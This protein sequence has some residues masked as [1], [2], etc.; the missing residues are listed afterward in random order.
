MATFMY[1]H[2]RG[3]MLLNITIMAALQAIRYAGLKPKP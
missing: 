3:M 2:C 1:I